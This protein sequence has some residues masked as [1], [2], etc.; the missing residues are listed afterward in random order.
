VGNHCVCMICGG[1]GGG[2]APL[3]YTKCIRVVA[4]AEDNLNNS[5]RCVH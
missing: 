1:G 3:Y 5:A 4:G 2:I